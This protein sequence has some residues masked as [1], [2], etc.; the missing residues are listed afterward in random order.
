MVSGLLS[1]WLSRIVVLLRDGGAS[2]CALGLD[3]LRSWRISSITD[4]RRLVVVGWLAHLG[5]MRGDCGF[6]LVNLYWSII[7]VDILG[8]LWS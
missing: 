7:G 8:S 3:R 2:D 4:E 1:N 6:I 5:G